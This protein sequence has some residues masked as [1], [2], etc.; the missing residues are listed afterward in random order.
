MKS[1]KGISVLFGDVSL[2]TVAFF[3]VLLSGGILGGNTAEAT[4]PPPPPTYYTL[5]VNKSGGDSTCEVRIDLPAPSAWVENYITQTFYVGTEYAPTYQIACPSDY[6]FSHWESND[7]ELDGWREN[8]S[9]DFTLTKNTTATA[10]FVPAA[11]VTNFRCFESAAIENP[12]P[13]VSGPVGTLSSVYHFDSSTGNLQALQGSILEILCYDTAVDFAQDVLPWLQNPANDNVTRGPA[14]TNA[15][16]HIEEPWY[17]LF[18]QTPFNGTYPRWVRFADT[19]ISILDEVDSDTAMLDDG[20][21]LLL[22]PNLLT[23]EG[24]YTLKQFYVW[25]RGCPDFELLGTYSI[26]RKSYGTGTKLSIEKSPG[27]PSFEHVVECEE[28]WD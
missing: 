8:R 3:T 17:S 13:C 27:C 25:N 16:S 20:N 6:G 15:A 2:A 7:E 9:P 1:S 5:T 21:G 19:P 14:F 28:G 10:V 11:T 4:Q 24:E 18:L 22:P 26:T 23:V 12:D